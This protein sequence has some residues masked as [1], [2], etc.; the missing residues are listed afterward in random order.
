LA[1]LSDFFQYNFFREIA[2]TLPYSE[3]E[4]S[5]KNDPTQMEALQTQ[6]KELEME[7]KILNQVI[8]GL[9]I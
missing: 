5:V 8:K 6:V 3:P 1:E 9:K 4:F 7:V 2:T